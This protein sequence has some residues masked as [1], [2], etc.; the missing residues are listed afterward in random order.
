MS[1]LISNKINDLFSDELNFNRNSKLIKQSKSN[2]LIRNKFQKDKI[3]NYELIKQFNKRQSEEDYYYKEKLKFF[4]ENNDNDISIKNRK[5]QLNT[6]E[7]IIKKYIKKESKNSF[8]NNLEN[9]NNYVINQNSITKFRVGS[10]NP[11]NN[12][13]LESCFKGIAGKDSKKIKKTKFILEGKIKEENKINENKLKRK[14]TNTKKNMKNIV[15][16][17]KQKYPKKE[18]VFDRI[19]GVIKESNNEITNEEENDNINKYKKKVSLKT[20]KLFDKSIKLFDSNQK[21]RNTTRTKN[22][23]LNNIK[24]SEKKKIEE[25]DSS[26][27]IKLNMDLINDDSSYSNS[28]TLKSIGTNKSKSNKNKNIKMDIKNSENDF[29]QSSKFS[30]ESNSKNESKIIANNK[31]D[32]F[33]DKKINQNN[34]SNRSIKESK[35]SRSG[36]PKIINKNYNNI[37]FYDNKSNKNSSDLGSSNSDSEENSNESKNIDSNNKKE[38]DNE[39]SINKKIQYKYNHG[40]GVLS[41]IPEQDNKKIFYGDIN[42]NIETKRP[43]N[44]ITLE[45]NINKDKKISRNLEIKK[46]NIIINNNVSNNITVHKKESD[47][48]NEELKKG[49]EINKIN[50]EQKRKGKSYKVKVRKKFPFCCL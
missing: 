17:E 37:Y 8:M 10:F 32:I 36:S 23:E 15:M 29:F 13:E 50:N 41:I 42:N 4:N 31:E 19:K 5:K 11:R 38:S 27:F 18:T 26:N 45:Q 21:L 16:V 43:E 46:N 12:K 9:R 48:K 39:N 24:H 20:K 40:E 34:K 44:I 30:N 25:N 22:Q 2:K 1:N 3:K 49:E 47:S 7:N 33:F 14:K 28:K 35:K 6:D